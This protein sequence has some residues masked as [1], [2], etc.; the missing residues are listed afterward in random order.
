MTVPSVFR[1]S[2]QTASLEELAEPTTR[3]IVPSPSRSP[4]LAK[5]MAKFPLSAS[6]KVKFPARSEIFCSDFTVPSA[7]MNSIQT[8]PWLEPPSSSPNAPTA[9]SFMPSPSRSPMLVDARPK[10]SESSRAPSKPPVVFEISCSARTVPSAFMKSLQ[11]APLRGPPSPSPSAPTTMSGRPSPSSKSVKSS[12]ARLP[13]TTCLI[14]V[15]VVGGSTVTVTV[16]VSMAEPS[17]IV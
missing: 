7:F 4:M 2:I 13:P 6:G 16:A 12:A 11:T 5:D 3:S 15:I 14:T 1:N 9:R 17:D 10:K 8:A